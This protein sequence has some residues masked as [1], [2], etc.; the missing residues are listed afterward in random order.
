MSR[1][2]SLTIDAARCLLD[3]VDAARQG[4]VALRQLPSHLRELLLQLGDARRIGVRRGRVCV[5]GRG[6]FREEDKEQS[7]EMDGGW[8]LLLERMDITGG[9]NSFW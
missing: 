9:G 3:V 4:G 7:A 2:C 5:R 8:Q 1:P 6:H